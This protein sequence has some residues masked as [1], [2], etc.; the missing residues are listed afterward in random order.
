[1]SQ[2]HPMTA[3][4]RAIHI[5]DVPDTCPYRDGQVMTLR[6]CHGFQAQRYY[7]QLL[8]EG[9]RRNGMF[10]YRPVCR[11]CQACEVLRVDVDAF[12]PSKEQRRIRNQGR[13]N[14]EHRLRTPMYTR[15]K[16]EMYAAYLAHQHE[17]D[18]EAATEKHYNRFLV[19]SC[20]G[21]ATLELQLWAGERLAGVGILD[22]LP[23]ALSSVYFY[24]DPA[25][26]RFS[27]GT[28]AALLEIE[29]ARAWRRKY[30]YFGYYIEDCP[31]MNYK[32]RFRPCETKRPDDTEWRRHVR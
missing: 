23:D 2:D 28:Y 9:Y 7:Q 1:V 20:L 25:F 5:M 22:R 13:R 32:R 4:E 17:R 31:S 10:L 15:E 27:P 11:M 16:A 21:S 18:E 3:F 29:L 6:F 14:F 12:R 19:E 24:F 30:H 8:D 26:A